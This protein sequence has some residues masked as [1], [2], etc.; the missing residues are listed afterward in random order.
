MYLTRTINKRIAKSYN[1]SYHDS[2]GWKEIQQVPLDFYDEVLT[3]KPEMLSYDNLNMHF[4]TS[5]LE[6]NRIL[7]TCKLLDELLEQ[8]IEFGIAKYE[9]DSIF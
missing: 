5:R 9:K 6:Y 8:K 7:V 4:K 3:Y 1:Q 2:L